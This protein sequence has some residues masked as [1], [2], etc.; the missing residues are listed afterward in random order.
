MF[1]LF[2]AVVTG[3]QVVLGKPAPE[4]FLAA[5]ARLGVEPARA[6][7]FED[8]PSGTAGA[9]AAGCSVVGVASHQLQTTELAALAGERTTVLRSL[10]DCDLAHFGL[11]PFADRVLGSLPLAAPLRFKGEVIRGFGRGSKVL[12]IPTANLDASKLGIGAAHACGIYLGWASVGSDATVHKMAR[13]AGGSPAAACPKPGNAAQ[14]GDAGAV[15]RGLVTAAALCWRTRCASR[16]QVMSIGWN[17]FFK[18]QTHKTVEPWLLTDFGRD[19][20][21]AATR[22]STRNIRHFIACSASVRLQCDDC[23]VSSCPTALRRSGARPHAVGSHAR[24]A[25]VPCAACRRGASVGGRG[26]SAARGRFYDAGSA[27]AHCALPALL[28]PSVAGSSRRE[29]TKCA[30][31]RYDDALRRLPASL[32]ADCTDQSGRGDDRESSGR[33]P[34]LRSSTIRCLSC[35][36]AGGVII[37]ARLVG[38]GRVQN[39]SGSG[40]MLPLLLLPSTIS[41]ARRPNNK[42]HRRLFSSQDFSDN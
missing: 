19:F 15:R 22:R 13:A 5:C 16:P 7:V 24:R 14:V 38:R 10:L 23:R 34:R 31:E 8:A 41:S 35:D 21:G 37:A 25:A 17:P 42:L 29:G 9:R 20:Y 11:P 12:G 2:Q 33:A 32:S 30:S 39:S 3:D 18:D 27:G 26:V 40:G 28:R 4:I 36:P 1:G 6:V